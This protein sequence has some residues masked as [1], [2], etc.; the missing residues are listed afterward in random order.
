[1]IPWEIPELVWSRVHIDFAGPLN[2]E[3]YLI[4]TDA[5]SKWPEVFRTRNVSFDVNEN[6]S[7]RDFRNPHP[8][9]VT[10]VVGSRRF[11]CRPLGSHQI[12]KCSSPNEPKSISKEVNDNSNFS[13]VDPKEISDGFNV[14]VNSPKSN[15][16]ENEDMG[17]SNRFTE[18]VTLPPK[19]SLS[20]R[21]KRNVKAPQRLNL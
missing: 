20:E 10:K 21:P 5:F 14:N 1:M 2:N 12:H 19:S 8:A 16:T 4:I 3:H 17:L 15:S 13:A 9:V 7:V 6:V 11:L 18:N